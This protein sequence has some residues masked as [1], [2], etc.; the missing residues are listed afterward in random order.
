[1]VA[2]TAPPTFEV[3]GLV[4]GYAGP[5]SRP[6][7][8]TAPRR[9]CRPGSSPTSGRPRSSGSSSA[10]SRRSC[11]D[12]VVTHE[13]SL[14]PYLAPLGGPYQRGRGRGHARDLRQGAG[15]RARGG[16]D[17]RRADD[18]PAAEGA[19]DFMGLSLPEHG[20]HAINENY[21]WGQAAGGMEMFCRYFHEIAGRAV[22]GAA[23][24]AA[25]GRRMREVESAPGRATLRPMSDRPA[26]PVSRGAAWKIV[27]SVVASPAR[28]RYLLKASMKRGRR[29]LQARRRGDGERRHAG[30]ASGCRSTATSS[31]GRSSRRRGR[32]C[33]GSRSRAGTAA[34]ARRDQR[35]LHR[36][37]ARHVQGR[38]PRSSPRGRSTADNRLDVVPDGI[39]AKCPSK[40]DADKPGEPAAGKQ[41]ATSRRSR[42]ARGGACCTQVVPQAFDRAQAAG[43]QRRVE[44]REE[45]DA[46]R[47][48]RDARRSRSAAIAP[49]AAPMR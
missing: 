38:A 28:S 24:M 1:M 20:Y 13:A 46:Q 37:G 31:T 4:G 2:I 29:V 5:A 34:P 48:R 42:A 49:A 27:A 17:R 3:H 23:E 12:A 14:E 39:M 33:T 6:S 30:A 26:A 32:C 47:R 11:P 10:S 19:G 21:D 9:S 16:L 41:P 36:P 43:A 15:V 25:A 7:S 44:R 8:R 40:Y 22:R 35:D 45:A 18:A